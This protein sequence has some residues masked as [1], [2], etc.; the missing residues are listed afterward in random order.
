MS[1][2]ANDAFRVGILDPVAASRKFTY[3]VVQR[4]GFIP[5]GFTELQAVKDAGAR[6]VRCDVLLVSCMLGAG[7]AKRE[8]ASVREVLRLQDMLIF[9][10][11]CDVVAELRLLYGC[12][13]HMVIATLTSV[14]ALRAL[15]RQSL[16]NG[17]NER[18]ISLMFQMAISR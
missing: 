8:L 17:G 1:P 10:T 5:L 11:R 12:N 9:M 13:D 18:V 15:L 7:R 2:R 6:A 3:Q 14:F 4:L 16:R